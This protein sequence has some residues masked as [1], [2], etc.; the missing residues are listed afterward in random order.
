MKLVTVVKYHLSSFIDLVLH[1]S[2]WTVSYGYLERCLDL[3]VPIE[4][5]C[6]VSPLRFSS[7]CRFVGTPLRSTQRG[8]G[9]YE[10]N[11]V[12]DKL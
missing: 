7:V 8:S 11:L 3:D 6:D 9:G 2:T 12:E 4:N 1:Y 5:E 10:H